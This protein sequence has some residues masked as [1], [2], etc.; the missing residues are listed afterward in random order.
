MHYYARQGDLVIDN[1]HFNKAPDGAS[2]EQATA[3]LVLS[4]RDSA[5]HTIE[6]FQA[7]RVCRRNDVIYLDVSRKVVVTHA[8]RHKPVELEAGEYA[9]FPLSEFDGDLRNV[10]D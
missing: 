1:A 9:I 5:P 6:D 3:P 2:F 7:L 10:E 4:G 8:G